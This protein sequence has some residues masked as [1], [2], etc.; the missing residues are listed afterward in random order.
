M[1]L[2]ELNAKKALVII[3]GTAGTGKACAVEDA[4]VEALYSNGYEVSL[5]KI[6]SG[7]TAVDDAGSTDDSG[8][9]VC[10]G[11]D[12]TFNRVVNR[13][14]DFESAPAFAYIPCGLTNSF[15]KSL[16]LPE[17]A[18]ANEAT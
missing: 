12:G 15:A 9:V 4:V 11:G 7:E 17:D 18:E 10:C 6:G 1:V 5:S 14:T 3:N 16:G 8:I 13:Y 2:M